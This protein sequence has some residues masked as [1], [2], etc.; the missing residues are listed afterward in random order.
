M[1]AQRIRTILQADQIL[2]IENGRITESGTHAELVEA[3][4]SYARMNRIQSSYTQGIGSIGRVAMT[5]NLAACAG[6]IAALVTAWV[7]MGKPDL[8]T[9]RPHSMT[10]R[11]DYSHDFSS[12]YSLY[13]ALSGR[14]LSAVDV[15]E[16]TSTTLDEMTKTHYDGY[17]IW[18]F[19]LSQ[20]IA[21]AFNLNVAVDN[22][23]NYKPDTYYAN[24]P[25]TLG[26][27]LTVGLSIDI[28]KCF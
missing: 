10:W 18:K 1:V 12:N 6:T 9:A 4:G 21:K 25:V 2:V 26:T 27:T 14:F 19:T 8:T 5:T 20:R 22:L 16:Y 28:D 15:T 3:G 17:S 13:A 24:S 11:M 23:F 7:I